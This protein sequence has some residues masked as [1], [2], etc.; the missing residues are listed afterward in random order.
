MHLLLDG[1]RRIDDWQVLCENR[2]IVVD[3]PILIVH[4]RDALHLVLQR[5]QHSRELTGLIVG[6]YID[7]MGI[8]IAWLCCIQ[9][10]TVSRTVN[11]VGS[12]LHRQVHRSVVAITVIV[13]DVVERTLALLAQTE[14]D[15]SLAQSVYT[16]VEADGSI[17]IRE[18]AVHTTGDVDQRGI[19]EVGYLGFLEVVGRTVE[20]E[21]CKL[22]SVLVALDKVLTDRYRDFVFTVGVAANT[23]FRLYHITVDHELHTIDRDIGVQVGNL[24]LQRERRCIGEIVAVQCQR[25]AA[26]EAVA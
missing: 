7:V 2:L 4:K 21:R 24:T 14:F 12:T 16:L 3:I 11:A 13:G 23:L 18:T 17:Q 22:M 19:N 9:G 26:D 15:R 1:I 6:R 25:T 8:G 10:C 5:W 20:W